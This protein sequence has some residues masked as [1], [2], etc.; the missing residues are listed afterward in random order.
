VK[1]YF[2]KLDIRSISTQER[3]GVKCWDFLWKRSQLWDRRQ[4]LEPMLHPLFPQ[5]T[6]TQFIYPHIIQYSMS[7][8]PDPDYN[9]SASVKKCKNGTA[10][11]HQ[12]TI[13]R[14]FSSGYAF[15]K[16]G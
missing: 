13:R 6:Y 12:A 15:H 11:Q 1:D 2:D 7:E 3:S 9:T 16:E 4:K 14:T 10:C 8:F 5:Y